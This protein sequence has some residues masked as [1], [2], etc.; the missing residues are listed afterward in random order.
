MDWNQFIDRLPADRYAQSV[1]RNEITL[2]LGEIDVSRYVIRLE[3]EALERRDIRLQSEIRSI[4]MESAELEFEEVRLEFGLFKFKQFFL[5]ARYDGSI[6]F[7][8]YLINC[9]NTFLNILDNL[10]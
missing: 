7:F 8:I 2:A 6:S 1:I 3:R 9:F 5:V 10:L 4:G